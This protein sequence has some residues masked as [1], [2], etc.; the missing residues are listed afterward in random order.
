[1][2]WVDFPVKSLRIT[3]MQWVAIGIVSAKVPS[4]GLYPR[5]TSMSA[6]IPH[7]SVVPSSDTFLLL[8]LHHPIPA[9][10]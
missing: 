1:M 5:W 2:T 4:Q 10:Y 9:I 8:C 3:T 6:V 7:P